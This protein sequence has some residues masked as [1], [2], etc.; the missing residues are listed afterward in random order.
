[1]NGR[2]RIVAAATELFEK[3]GF[4]SATMD[5]IAGKAGVSKGL[6]YHHYASKDEL[7]AEITRQRVAEYDELIDALREEPGAERRLAI[8]TGH[9]RRELLERESRQRFLL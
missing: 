6:A 2:E 7:L 3:Q 9:L 8:L 5:E 4:E 1:M